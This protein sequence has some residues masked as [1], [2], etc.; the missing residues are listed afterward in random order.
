LS[1]DTRTGATVESPPLTRSLPAL[2]FDPTVTTPSRPGKGC[3]DKNHLHEREADC[4]K[5]PK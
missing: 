5:P 4:K 3:G 1:I 2:G